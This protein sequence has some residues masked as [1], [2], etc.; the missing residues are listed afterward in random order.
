MNRSKST[1][2]LLIVGLTGVVMLAG[3]TAARAQLPGPVD[4]VSQY[5]SKVGQAYDPTVQTPS[6][7]AKN[8]MLRNSNLRAP[9]D[10]LV[11]F[12]AGSLAISNI[13]NGRPVNTP[14]Q[15]TTS[16]LSSASRTS[17]PSKSSSEGRP[18]GTTAKGT[19]TRGND[20]K[21]QP[22]A[23]PSQQQRPQLLGDIRKHQ[24]APVHSVHKGGYGNLRPVVH[25]AAQRAQQE[26][27]HTQPLQ[28][29]ATA[30]HRGGSGS[31]RGR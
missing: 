27:H 22:G 13:A 30:S 20:A 23:Q 8:E 15:Q 1:K 10:A 19:P 24:N 6:Q 7:F 25:P 16:Q 5:E 12:A 4:M 29:H 18:L 28:K 11:G 26:S 3:T 9:A 21:G 31:V 14:P 17:A 2:C